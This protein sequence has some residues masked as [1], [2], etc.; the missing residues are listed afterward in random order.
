MRCAPALSMNMSVASSVFILSSL[1]MLQTQR[2]IFSASFVAMN[3]ASV[4]L[5]ATVGCSQDLWI[6]LPAMWTVHPVTNLQFLMF[7]TQLES[8]HAVGRFT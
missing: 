1:R 6:G 2:M 4:E 5:S 7:P 8:A 3:S